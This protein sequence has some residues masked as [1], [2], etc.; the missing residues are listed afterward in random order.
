MTEHDGLIYVAG[1]HVTA[2]KE[3]AA[4]LEQAQRRAAHLQKMEAIGQLTGGIAHDFNN[5][6]MIVSGHA[7]RLKNRL[8][9]AK[10]VRALQAIQMAASRGENLT[11]QLLGFARNLP[12]DPTVLNLADAVQVCATFWPA[13]STSISNSSST[14]PTTTWPVCVDKPELELA[15]VNLAVNAR[16]AMADGGRLSI[17]ARERASCGGRHA[18]GPYRRCRR[19]HDRRYRQ[20]H[21]ARLTVPRGR[22][23]LHHQRPRQG[24]RPRLVPGLRLCPALG[25]HDADRERSRPR[26]RG[27]DLS[28]A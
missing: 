12:L 2:E 4:A 6:L 21:S 25:R 15:L 10:D 23:V 9:D 19:A 13:R 22:A 17:A 24:H 8:A 28:A 3:A 14:F 1:R 18:R 20:R 26:H 5:L 11:R 16:D 27:D 7:Q